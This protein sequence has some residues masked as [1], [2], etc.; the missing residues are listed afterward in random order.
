MSLNAAWSAQLSTVSALSRRSGE[1]CLN[2]GI[3]LFLIAT[4][5][6]Q[7]GN[8]VRIGVPRAIIHHRSLETPPVLSAWRSFHNIQST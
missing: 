8:R 6:G 5:E 2:A 7:I 4:I 1:V 3:W